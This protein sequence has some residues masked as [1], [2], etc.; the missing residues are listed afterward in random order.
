MFVTFI[1]C[2]NWINLTT[3]WKPFLLIYIFAIIQ[4][5]IVFF[6]NWSKILILAHISSDFKTFFLKF[7][8]I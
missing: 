3:K 7:F 6:G 5:E 4:K 8:L 2:T 1:L